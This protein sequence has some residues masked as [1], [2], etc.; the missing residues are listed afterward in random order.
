MDAT[1]ETAGGVHGA[2]GADAEATATRPEHEGAT[3]QGLGR[4]PRIAGAGIT[5]EEVVENQ[6]NWS[7]IVHRGL[8]SNQY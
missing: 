4:G 8:L 5:N 2:A 7:M 1:A 6:V 3:I